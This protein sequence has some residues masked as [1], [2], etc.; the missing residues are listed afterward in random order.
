VFLQKSTTARIGIGKQQ[1]GG[2]DHATERRW[3][4]NLTDKKAPAWKAKA[5]G[6][7]SGRREQPSTWIRDQA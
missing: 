4:P 7:S 3:W 2:D 1:A 6:R 5:K